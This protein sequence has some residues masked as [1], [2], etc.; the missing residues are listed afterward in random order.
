MKKSYICGLNTTRYNPESLNDNTDPRKIDSLCASMR[1]GLFNPSTSSTWQPEGFFELGVDQQ[2][3][4]TGYADYGLDNVTFGSTGVVLPSAI[5]GSINDTNY[6]LGYFG[7]GIVPGNFTNI[8]AIS[9]I[10]GLVEKEGAIPSHSY[11]YT[12]GAKYREFYDRAEY[13]ANTD[14]IQNKRENQIR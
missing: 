1:G 14:V 5:I 6:W 4:N 9:A 10:S 2:L 12:A 8:T 13:Q 7:L 3:G 11:G